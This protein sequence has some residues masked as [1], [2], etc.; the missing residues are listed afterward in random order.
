MA[1][2]VGQQIPKKDNLLL[3]V[4]KHN[5][6]SYPGEPTTNRAAL[7]TAN[8]SHV[9]QWA[10]S[11]AQTTN[12]ND[13]DVPRPKGF[14]NLIAQIVSSEVTAT[15]SLFFASGLAYV[16]GNTQYSFSIYYRQNRVGISHASYSP[17]MRGGNHNYNFGFLSYNGSTDH[18]TWPANEWIR[19]EGTMTAPADADYL[20]IS[21]YIGATVGDKC[22]LFG[23]QIEEGP[24]VTRLTVS[25]RSA[26]GG[27]K[28]LSKKQ[29]HGDFTA[30][31]FE[32]TEITTRPSHKRVK[33]FSF[34]ATDDTV[35]LDSS[36]WPN[37][38]GT[39][40]A[41]V[42]PN[43][44]GSATYPDHKWILGNQAGT[45][46]GMGIWSGNGYLYWFEGWTYQSA[47][48]TPASTRYWVAGNWY[49][50]CAT[51]KYPLDFDNQTGVYLYQNAY[52]QE[53]MQGNTQYNWTNTQKIGQRFDGK[54]D[55]VKV[56]DKLLTQEEITQ[57]FNRDRK[58]YGY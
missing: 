20:Y 11:G 2:S 50:L 35:G 13:T 33:D 17:Y 15:G 53:T 42:S 23:P 48:G 40:M 37:E 51:W 46:K 34:D 57:D 22:W 14:K 7:H 29:T 10:N 38:E 41:W 30:A 1:T 52:K 16:T 55:S 31:S 27:W 45:W 6:N 28:D 47:A 54:I 24:R 18:N 44:T 26:T 43:F 25:P 39:V 58:R 4:D 36:L 12:G 8:I 3:Y 5:E 49:H 56:Y 21:Q 19:L 9:H 32:E